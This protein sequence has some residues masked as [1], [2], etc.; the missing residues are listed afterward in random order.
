MKVSVAG[1]SMDDRNLGV[2]SILIGLLVIAV[3]V[4]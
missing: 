2:V 3:I 4:K 1:V